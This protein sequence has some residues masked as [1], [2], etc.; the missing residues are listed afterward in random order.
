[1]ENVKRHPADISRLLQACSF[2]VCFFSFSFFS[3][4]LFSF[5]F[6]RERFSI[7]SNVL[8]EAAVAL[9]ERDH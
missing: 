5:F 2:F 1:M 9:W 7:L 6:T 8:L 4:F 3:V